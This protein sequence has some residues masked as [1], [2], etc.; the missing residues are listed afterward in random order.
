M[1]LII[2]TEFSHFKHRD[3]IGLSELNGT[4]N[5]T[6]MCHLLNRVEKRAERQSAVSNKP[7]MSRLL[8]YLEHREGA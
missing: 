1:S 3:I 6:P 8:Q 7:V 5:T 2:F 4:N